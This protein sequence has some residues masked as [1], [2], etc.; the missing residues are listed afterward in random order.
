MAH[1]KHSG[2]HGK[3]RIKDQAAFD[4]AKNELKPAHKAMVEKTQKA[5]EQSGGDPAVLIS[6]TLDNGEAMIKDQRA[7]LDKAKQSGDPAAIGK[8][9]DDFVAEWE[10]AVKFM[11]HPATDIV[12]A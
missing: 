11:R 2:D 5:F 7:R 12:P 3:H 6:T 8:A 4:K 1:D 10:A 9:M